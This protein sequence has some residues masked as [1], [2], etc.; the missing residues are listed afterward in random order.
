MNFQLSF[1]QIDRLEGNFGCVYCIGNSLSYLPTDAMTSFLKTVAG[2]LNPSGHFILQVVNW[3]KYRLTVNADFEVKTLS[4][5]RT[6]HRQ[7]EPTDNDAV[8]FKTELRI[9]GSISG[10]WSDPLYPKYMEDLASGLSAA[11][12]P[13]IEQ[14]G[15]FE[16]TPFIPATSPAAVVV[17]KKANTV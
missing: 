14:F 9:G 6:F 3:D 16:K 10:A 17:A 15:D 11:G 4:D 8:L 7:Y 12:L 2:L 13:P 5:G 1:T